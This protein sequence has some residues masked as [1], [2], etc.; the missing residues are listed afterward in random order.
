[1]QALVFEKTPLWR[2]A[3]GTDSGTLLV[4]TREW[5]KNIKVTT[6]TNIVPPLKTVAMVLLDLQ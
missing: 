5:T 3:H 6:D 2:P 4:A 1:M